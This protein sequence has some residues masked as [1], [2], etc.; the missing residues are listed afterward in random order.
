[1]FCPEV[2]F[3]PSY[4]PGSYVPRV[5]PLVLHTAGVP[6]DTRSP[7][8]LLLQAN[9]RISARWQAIL[10]TCPYL[11]TSAVRYPISPRCTAVLLRDCLDAVQHYSNPA[12][13][14]ALRLL[15]LRLADSKHAVVPYR[16]ALRDHTTRHAD[17]KHAVVPS[18]RALYY[19]K[20]CHGQAHTHACIHTHSLTCACRYSPML[21]LSH[22]LTL[23]LSHLCMQI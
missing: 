17:S 4:V 7:G 20:T 9:C 5:P 19:H 14:T 18:R 23:S 1:M 13:A 3:I 2:Q 15:D 21:S 12:C 6:S 10:R 22:S 8:V 16:R 11:C